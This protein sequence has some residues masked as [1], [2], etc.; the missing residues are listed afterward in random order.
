M[1][2]DIA[3]PRTC[4]AGKQAWTIMYGGHS[5]AD[6][7]VFRRFH[8]VDHFHQEKQLTIAGAWRGIKGFCI[9]PV[10]R[11]GDFEAAVDNL[12]AVFNIGLVAAPAFAVRRIGKH[13]VKLFAL[14][15]VGGKGWADFDVFGVVAFNHHV[16][17]ADG[18]GLVIDFFAE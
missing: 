10:V 13:K 4:V 6:F 15:A 11:Q 8:F 14:E 7:V 16:G 1:A 5:A 18:V 17:F 12:I 2:T 3:L 9:A